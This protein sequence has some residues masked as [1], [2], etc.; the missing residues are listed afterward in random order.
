MTLELQ[1][2]TKFRVPRGFRGRS[3]IIV[4]LWQLAQATLFGMSPQPFYAWR[5]ALLRL[6]GAKIGRQVIVRPT[7]RI[8]YPW[9]IEIGDFSWIGDRVELYSLDRITIGS[10]SVVSQQSY[11]CTATHDIHDIAFSYITA[12][13]VIGDQ[14][15]VAADVFVAPG[16]T[17]GGGAVVGMRSTVLKDVPASMVAFG[18]PAEVRHERCA[19]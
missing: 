6:F 7:A 2:L 10:N 17:I 18:S 3:G 11:L 5:R 8:T 4:L 14:A 1:D 19:R 9:K 12:P 16:V 13:I 15:W